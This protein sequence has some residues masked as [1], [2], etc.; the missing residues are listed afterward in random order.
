MGYAVP[1]LRRFHDGGDTAFAFM[2]T[3]IGVHHWPYDVDSYND[4]ALVDEGSLPIETNSVD[5]IIMVHDLEYADFPEEVI[6]EAYRILKSSGRMLVIAPNR[7][8]FWVRSDKTPFGYGRPFS[9]GQLKELLEGAQFVHEQTAEALF[10][11][12][13]IFLPFLR[14]AQMFEQV[15]QGVFPIVAGVHMVEVSK[16]LYARI[17]RGSAVSA[18]IPKRR[19]GLVPNYFKK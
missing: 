4:V 7:S 15:G 3:S 9:I 14:L 10:M 18:K 2:P 13:T 11:P 17:D 8:G 16:Q 6:K 12:P 5:R 19:V 1:Y